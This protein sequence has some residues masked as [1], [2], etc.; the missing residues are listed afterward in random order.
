MGH[1]RQQQTPQQSTSLPIAP[2]IWLHPKLLMPLIASPSFS[3][4]SDVDE[5]RDAGEE[6]LQGLGRL[7]SV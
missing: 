3:C 7:N 1:Q 5:C 6:G 2:K 4:H